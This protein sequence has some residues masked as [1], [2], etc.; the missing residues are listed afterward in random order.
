MVSDAGAD[1][2]VNV[3]NADFLTLNPSSYPDVEHVLLDPSCSG[4]G[5]RG[6]SKTES[7]EGR[8][9]SLAFLQAK[10][11]AHAISF[12]AVRSVAYSTCSVFKE[13]NEM[14]SVQK[15]ICERF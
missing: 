2:I 15:L 13:E 4:S 3:Q 10:M 5:M 1:S 7:G 9:R 14:V 12:P 6:A 8:L 11:L